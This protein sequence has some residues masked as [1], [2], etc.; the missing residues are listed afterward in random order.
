MRERRADVL[1]PEPST[2]NS[3]SSNTRGQ[4]RR[5]GQ[6]GAARTIRHAR[7]RRRHHHL[8]PA[9]HPLEA[10]SQRHGLLARSRCCACIC[11]QHVCSSGNTTSCPSRSS[12][13]TTARPVPGNSVSLKQVTKRA[14][15][16]GANPSQPLLARARR[17]RRAARLLLGVRV[18]LSGVDGEDP[19]GGGRC[20]AVAGRRQREQLLR[21]AQ[22]AEQPAHRALDRLRL[23]QVAQHQPGDVLGPVRD[24]GVRLLG[25][26]PQVHVCLLEPAAGRRHIRRLLVAPRR[27]ARRQLRQAGLDPGMVGMALGDLLV[28]GGDRRRGLVADRSVLAPTRDRQREPPAG[29]VD[30]RG[31]SRLDPRRRLAGGARRAPAG[32]EHEPGRPAVAAHAQLRVAGPRPDRAREG[33]AGAVH[34]DPGLREP[35]PAHRAHDRLLERAVGRRRGGLDRPRARHP[36]A[37]AGVGGEPDRPPVLSQR[38]VERVL[39][40]PHADIRHSRFHDRAD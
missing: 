32:G 26:C 27:K 25:R 17:R 14:T 36:L 5:P 24:P 21:A 9:E 30:R 19:R 38:G 28:G 16:T 37:L 13:S 1:H 40:R 33:M 29:R 2:R 15:R 10:R 22:L 8:A 20:D 31:G 34:L 3:V 6:P 23:R 12:T 39:R 7:R 4:L 18:V 11:P 35:D